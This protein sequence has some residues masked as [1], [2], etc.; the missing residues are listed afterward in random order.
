MSE[1]AAQSLWTIHIS[2]GREHRP[3]SGGDTTV[4][5]LAGGFYREVDGKRALLVQHLSR[6]LQ[7]LSENMAKSLGDELHHASFLIT[8]DP[9]TVAALGILPEH[10]DCEEC[11][12]QIANALAYMEERPGVEMLVG[13]LFW[14]G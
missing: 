13:H 5:N 7:A 9:A 1:A 8:N 12:S 14:A 2:T 3:V 11:K 10:R 4:L 6:W